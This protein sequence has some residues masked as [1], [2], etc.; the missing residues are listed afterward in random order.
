L[1]LKQL[2]RHKKPIVI[3]NLLGYYDTMQKMLDEAIEKNFMKPTCRELCAFLD[4]AEE[5]LAYM[6]QYHADQ[7]ET[8]YYKNI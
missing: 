1:T 3:F 4:G 5:V 8:K 7:V 2:G 6:E